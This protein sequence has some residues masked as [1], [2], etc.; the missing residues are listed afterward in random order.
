MKRQ[1]LN[2]IPVVAAL[3]ATLSALVA[4]VLG[5]AS[6]VV[7]AMLAGSVILLL[8]AIFA[9]E[10]SRPSATKTAR[11]TS[12]LG[13][14]SDHLS[15]LA[16][17][18][19]AAD[20]RALGQQLST[21]L[22]LMQHEIRAESA[23]D[24]EVS[25]RNLMNVDA[26]AR[27]ISDQMNDVANLLDDV[28]RRLHTLA[29]TSHDAVK[30]VD[31][32]KVA[33]G[34]VSTQLRQSRKHSETILIST[35]R[36]DQTT[37]ATGGRIT[38]A[39]SVRERLQTRIS[40]MDQQATRLADLARGNHARLKDAQ[41]AIERCQS[42]VASASGLVETLSRR[43]KEIINTIDVIDDIA[44][45]TNLLALNASIEAARAGEQGQGF[46]VVAEEVRKLAARS[47]TATRSINELLATIQSEAEEAARQL[48]SGDASVQ[49]ASSNVREFA[50]GFDD[51]QRA[52][53]LEQS[54]LDG[55]G[56][57]L[58]LLFANLAETAKEN[59]ESRNTAVSLTRLVDETSQGLMQ[60]A[61]GFNE[62]QGQTEKLGRVVAR[63]SIEFELLENLVTAGK[64]HMHETIVEARE[65]LVASTKAA[66][67]LQDRTTLNSSTSS[68]GSSSASSRS[69][70]W[71]QAPLGVAQR[72]VTQIAESAATISSMQR[73]LRIKR[74]PNVAPADENTLTGDPGN[75]NVGVVG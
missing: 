29:T 69:P 52:A 64:K 32:S 6:L 24:C 50:P 46:A 39:L 9:P 23:A 10:D 2:R 17:T 58:E 13:S 42:D 37:A 68:A 48:T 5:A 72:Y 70:S 56:Q 40:N 49:G 45:Q 20:I 71:G 38:D 41:E 25:R 66:A 27:L 34:Q 1:R 74:V 55:L 16:V 15:D 61:S 18:K 19:A 60:M 57:E 43:A 3:I 31:A 54:E 59:K 12:T 51:I 14:V 63:Q 21:T 53:H 33:W 67:S 11:T 62:L 26:A 8:V 7:T 47:S 73:P 28:S 22:G 44:E 35:R 65:L 30:D 75:I 4:T 36:L